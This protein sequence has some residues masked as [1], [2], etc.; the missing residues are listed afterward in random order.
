MT[1]EERERLTALLLQSGKVEIGQL[2]VGDH[3]TATQNNYARGEAEQTT[4]EATSKEVAAAVRGCSELWYG[5]SAMTVV[6][7][8]CRDVCHWTV[9]QSDFERMMA[10]EGLECKSG[11]LANAL[12]NNPYMRDHISK[13][14]SL[15]ARSEV[16]KLR[17]ALCEGLGVE[18]AT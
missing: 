7:A 10:L 3:N 1:Q 4:V 14:A 8:V 13:W 11:T 5:A 15:G 2:L 9:G 16:L 18:A 12:R 6:Y 17:D